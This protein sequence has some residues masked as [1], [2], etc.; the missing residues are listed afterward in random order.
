[1]ENKKMI[2]MDELPKTSEIKLTKTQ[3]F[4]KPHLKQ[5]EFFWWFVFWLMVLV[6]LWKL[7]Q[8]WKEQKK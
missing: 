3:E 8:E 1:M 7:F 4:L 5:I 6:L 2:K